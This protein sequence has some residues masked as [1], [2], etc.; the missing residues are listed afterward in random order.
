M[1][2]SFKFIFHT[3]KLFYRF[4]DFKDLSCKTYRKLIKHLY[5]TLFIKEGKMSNQAN[6]VGLTQKQID[7]AMRGIR[8]AISGGDMPNTDI[9][10]L[11]EKIE[12]GK[13]DLL[14]TLN[15]MLRDK[16]AETNNDSMESRNSSEKKEKSNEIKHSVLE[17]LV[18]EA[19]K[20]QLT[21]WLNA[22]LPD[23]VRNIVEKEIK[24]LV[25]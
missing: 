12:D 17:N 16:K 15:T 3:M 10:E 1:V 20:P 4:V 18:I 2:T 7:D 6:N 24:K 11:T 13:D 23:I 8:E 22:N 14:N 19:L 21:N 25:P 9:L 5:D